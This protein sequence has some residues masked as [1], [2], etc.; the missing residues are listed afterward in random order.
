VTRNEIVEVMAKAMF[1]TWQFQADAADDVPW[2]E[3]GNSKKQDE[4]RAY[5]TAALAALEA[6]GLVIVPRVPSGVML[7]AA[8][9]YVMLCNEKAFGPTAGGVYVAMV[10]ASQE[11]VK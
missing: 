6:V 9:E 10:A 8:D 4:A 7:I 11:D 3:G 2:V 1:L 5:A